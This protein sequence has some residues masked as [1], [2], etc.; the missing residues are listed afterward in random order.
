MR[1]SLLAAAIAATLTLPAATSFAAVDQQVIEATSLDTGISQDV[2]ANVANALDGATTPEAIQ[3]AVQNLLNGADETAQQ[4]ILTAALNL[5][6]SNPA[7]QSAIGRAAEAANVPLGTIAAASFAANV[8]STDVLEATAAGAGNSGNANAN[9]ANGVNNSNGIR[10]N[11]GIGY[12]SSNGS[13]GGGS[14]SAG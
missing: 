13:G 9:N 14:A 3:A 8:D 10:G 12:G 1:R 6:A 11:N 2:V 4:S 5:N 7:A